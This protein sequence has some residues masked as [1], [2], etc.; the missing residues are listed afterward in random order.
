MYKARVS[1][2]FGM[3]YGLEC[4][5]WNGMM[6]WIYITPYRNLINVQTYMV[7]QQIALTKLSWHYFM[8]YNC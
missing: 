7:E 4:G 8:R 3:E 6:E 5:M 1:L 2:I